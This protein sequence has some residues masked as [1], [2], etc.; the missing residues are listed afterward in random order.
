MEGVHPSTVFGERV[1]ISLHVVIEEGCII[2][3]GTFL[4]VGCVL[5]TNTKIGKNCIIGHYCIFEGG[6]LLGDRITM[7]PHAIITRNAI[8]EDD[9]FIGPHYLGLNDKK[10]WHGRGKE[11]VI[12]IPPIIKR[13]AR[14]GAS[15]LVM[16][17]IVIGE[18]SL[19]GAGSV[20]TR[21]VEPR[22]IVCGNP[23]KLKG[24]VPEEEIL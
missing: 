4:G 3:D 16:P 20:V 18:N 14:V 24:R 22:T 1:R 8:V 7:G 21:D 15:A 9:V 2:G 5:R 12:L 23:A 11:K 10:V 6:C 17:G 13:A 19:V